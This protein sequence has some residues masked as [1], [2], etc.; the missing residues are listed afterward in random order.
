VKIKYTFIS[1]NQNVEGKI[2][3]YTHTA[4]KSSDNVAKLKYLEV[5]ATN[6]NYIHEEIKRTLNSR[7]VFCHY[8]SIKNVLPP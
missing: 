6:Q 7:N 2:I 8:H 3:I 1:Q 5:T 4:S